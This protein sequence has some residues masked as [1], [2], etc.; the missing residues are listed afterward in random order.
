MFIRIRILNREKQNLFAKMR[1][2]CFTKG[3]EYGPVFFKYKF[4]PHQFL[5]KRA[6]A[7]DP[8]QFLLIRL[9]PGSASVSLKK[10]M[11]SGSEEKNGQ[12]KQK[13]IQTINI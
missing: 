2:T 9:G 5:F 3:K 8:H 13:F 6:W 1:K 7:L 12:A 10:D 11:G 4:D